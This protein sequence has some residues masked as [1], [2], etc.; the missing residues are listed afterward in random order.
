MFHASNVSTIVD[1]KDIIDTGYNPFYPNPENQLSLSPPPP[2]Q[3]QQQQ[4]PQQQQPPQQF[5]DVHNGFDRKDVT[6]NNPSV[7]Y[8]MARGISFNKSEVTNK[9]IHLDDEEIKSCSCSMCGAQ[10]EKTSFYCFDCAEYFCFNCDELMHKNYSSPIWNHKRAYLGSVDK[11]QLPP[12]L[13]HIDEYNIGKCPKHKRDYSVYCSTDGMYCCSECLMGNEHVN[14]VLFH[15]TVEF[16]TLLDAFLGRN[17]GVDVTANSLFR[18]IG[19]LSYMRGQLEKSKAASH[20]KIDSMF[21]SLATGIKERQD[22]LIEEAK[23]KKLDASLHTYPGGPGFDA[24][25]EQSTADVLK[26]LDELVN[27]LSQALSLPEESVPQKLE[28]YNDALKKFEAIKKEATNFEY[29]AFFSIS[30]KDSDSVVRD[31]K[32][33]GDIACTEASA[34]ADGGRTMISWDKE[35][36]AVT[37]T[38]VIGKTMRTDSGAMM[39]PAPSIKGNPKIETPILIYDNTALSGTNV[40]KYFFIPVSPQT[41]ERDMTPETYRSI[42]QATKVLSPDLFYLPPG[43]KSSDSYKAKKDEFDKLNSVRM[44]FIAKY[45]ATKARSI[46]E[47]HIMRVIG[48]S[49]GENIVPLSGKDVFS[50]F[51]TET[52]SV[53]TTLIEAATKAS[54]REFTSIHTDVQEAVGRAVHSI[55][56]ELG[57]ERLVK[58][59]PDPEKSQVLLLYLGASKVQEVEAFTRDLAYSYWS[60][61]KKYAAFLISPGQEALVRNFDGVMCDVCNVQSLVY[62]QYTTKEKDIKGYI[63]NF[64]ERNCRFPCWYVV[65]KNEASY[66]VIISASPRIPIIPDYDSIN[67]DDF[68]SIFQSNYCFC[69]INKM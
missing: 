40:L 23:A 34:Y 33:L 2:Q 56:N 19:A 21:S 47:D 54:S 26:K 20:D 1:E 52:K 68:K 61:D 6:N 62:L 3:Q 36:D 25:D 63:T 5:F 32:G 69:N 9:E 43:I 51:F 24:S 7:T 38:A 29:K 8:T 64:V 58:E 46:V 44:E 13:P 42:L 27:D 49:L 67:P 16:K 30:A 65:L 57:L 37:Q 41:L 48:L 50:V 10:C 11:S 15:V 4:Q 31:L 12:K 39:T 55:L 28:K 60:H 18:N 14:H 35:V 66:R 22:S 59:F 53:L 45:A 17:A